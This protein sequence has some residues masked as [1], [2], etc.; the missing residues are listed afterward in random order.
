MGLDLLEALDVID[1]QIYLADVV[2]IK[3]SYVASL[4]GLCGFHELSQELTAS[5]SELLEH[6]LSCGHGSVTSWGLDE[7]RFGHG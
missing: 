1:Y 7:G 2:L 3:E 5:T 6:L 4:F